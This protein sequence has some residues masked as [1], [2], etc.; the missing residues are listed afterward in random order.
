MTQ[1]STSLIECLTILL[2]SLVLLIRWDSAFINM[3]QKKT[4]FQLP[5]DFCYD[6]HGHKAQH[7]I[8]FTVRAYYN[9]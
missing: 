5:L 4:S 6:I 1:V 8:G 3:L 7:S 9:M 2:A